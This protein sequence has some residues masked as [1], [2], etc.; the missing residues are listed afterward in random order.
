M[1][2]NSWAASKLPTRPGGL[3]ANPYYEWAV[4]TDFAYY[5]KSAQW[6]P[7][8][9]ELHE[10]TAQEFARQVFDL[11]KLEEREQGWAAEIRVPPFFAN[12]PERLVRP[13]RFI[14][15][16]ATRKFLQRINAGEAPGQ[17]IRRFELGRAT[18][19]YT[20][21]ANPGERETPLEFA[22]FPPV[23]IT[24]VIDD[25]IAFSHNRFWSTNDTT[26]IEYFWDQRKPSTWWP[27]WPYWP[28]WNYGHEISK[29]DPYDGI[30][31][32]M[33]TSKYVAL[34]D[35]DEVYRR[36]AFLDFARPGHKPLAGRVSHGTHVMDVACH[37]DPMP[38]RGTR[39]IIA[40]Q[41][42]C[43][44]V[45]D[46]SGATLGPQVFEGLCYIICRAAT[47][48]STAMTGQ[49]PVVV[50]VSYGT[51]AGPH[52]GS[53]TFEVALDHLLDLCNPLDTNGFP[54]T[55]PFRV[56]LPAGNNHL[57]RCHARVSLSPG[58]Q[59]ELAWRVLPDD[60]TESYV[61][62]WLPNGASSL[63]F[64]ITAPDGQTTG[65]FSAGNKLV[66]GSVAVPLAIVFYYP[67]GLVGP[68]AL[69]WFGLAPTSAPDGGLPV[70]PAGVWRIGIDNPGVT[71]VDD[72]EAWIQR[73]D[74]AP[75]YARRGR[76][77]YFDDPDY[78]RYN[79]GGREIEV[80]ADPRTIASY[81]K[82]EGTLNAMATGTEPIVIGGFRRSDRVAA[83]Y[84]AS[85]RKLHPPGPAS[86]SDIAPQA[87]TPS[88]D[89]PSHRGVL[90]AGTRS[91]SCS[92]MNGTSVAAPRAARLLAERM[93]S[94]LPSDRAAVFN[95]A[96]LTDPGPPKPPPERTGGGR[97][98]SP[99]DRLP[100]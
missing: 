54:T 62:I 67:P 55:P 59:R 41:L 44:T 39:P 23:V 88:E 6:L 69:V 5:G 92:P 10:R 22:D 76:Q 53:S 24:G 63:T 19:P 33:Q 78:G 71:Q 16:L 38:A 65:A 94:G 81:V 79:D 84:S 50:N 45:A 93:V 4:A 80:D 61:E 34:V 12:P 66:H 51:I 8:L 11:Q 48:A 82:R 7:M 13:L 68:R 90:A 95:L 30:D 1:A 42:P 56:V 35:E 52:D 98:P 46:T 85:G 21:K 36:S 9:I 89:A 74:S 70:A 60:W 26:R 72:I 86:S 37:L 73:D 99:P 58:Q 29:R 32:L 77:S 100:R 3:L 18:I 57:S 96:A 91:S 28:H 83:S 17:L 15:V 27:Y 43:A 20:L 97:I 64:N 25:G 14:S 40:V 49:L 2:L 47:I 31:T 87:M 75:G